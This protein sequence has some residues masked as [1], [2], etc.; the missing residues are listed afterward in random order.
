[1]LWKKAEIK[2]TMKEILEIV[3]PDVSLV[4]VLVDFSGPEVQYLPLQILKQSIICFFLLHV[5]W[6]EH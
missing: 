4:D 6:K 3:S 1:M 5:L 2:P